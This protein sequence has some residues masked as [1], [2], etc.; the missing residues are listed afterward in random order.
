[1]KERNELPGSVRAAEVARRDDG[2]SR[3]N[4]RMRCGWDKAKMCFQS[5]V[6]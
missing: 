4:V 6:I 2:M 1:M 5:N 3:G